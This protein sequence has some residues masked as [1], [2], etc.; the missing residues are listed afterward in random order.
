[1]TQRVVII[2]AG[3]RKTMNTAQLLDAA[4]RGA[5]EAGAEVERIRLF[6]LNVKDCY[7]CMA[8]KRK[9]N[10][11]NGLCAV[12]DDLR[13]VLE[14]CYDADGIII[15]SPI[16]FSCLTAETQALCCRL[17]FPVMH[18][19][20]DGFEPIKKKKHIGL[21]MSMNVNELLLD[22][23][24]YRRRFDD[25]AQMLGNLLGSAETLYSCDTLQ[26]DDYSKYY[27]DKFN[28]A[29]K[30]K[31]HETQFPKDLEAAFELGK[32]VAQKTE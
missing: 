10:T 5:C 19:S 27:A 17:M 15:G 13:P 26:F 7:A 29:H 16:Y 18:Y 21:V 4:E 2:D 6:H 3:P 23:M 11:T 9:G 32:R 22:Q 20:D 14:A 25:Y 28:E 1:M 12:R 30:I 8:C 31:H 24:G